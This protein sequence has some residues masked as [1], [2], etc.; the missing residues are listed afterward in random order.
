MEHNL[1][2]PVYLNIEK[3]FLHLAE[4]IHIDDS[5]LE[6]YSMKI[7]ELLIRT[8]VEFESLAK[9]LY[10]ANGGTKT[11][12]KELYF[13]TDCM[14]HLVNIWD[15]DKKVVMVSSPILFL[16]KEEN[17]L[18]TPL[19]KTNK[20]G[21][22]SADWCKAYQAVKH[23]RVKDLR[24]GSIKNLLRALAALY[25]LNLYYRDEKVS[26]ITPGK[27]P[28]KDF[29]FGSQIFS[30][31]S[32]NNISQVNIDG[33][34]PKGIDFEKYI[35]VAV[36]DDVKYKELVALLNKENEESQSILI[37]KLDSQIKAGVVLPT[38]EAI[39]KYISEE[40]GK[41][42]TEVMQKYARETGRKFMEMSYIAELN[43]NQ[44]FFNSISP[45]K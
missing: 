5:Q 6:V 23:N 28:F 10:F 1:Y 19:H 24:K 41:V 43:K 8:A 45:T 9:N 4:S 36:P 13:D 39:S 29:S 21:S 35:Y 16:G 25:I 38:Q 12:D 18:L 3:E 15:I 7:A 14:G 42:T 27:E 2:W 20:R 31:M 17:I 11:D 40:R 26:F 33:S 34:Y 30:V 32:P 44:S 37:Q 22:S